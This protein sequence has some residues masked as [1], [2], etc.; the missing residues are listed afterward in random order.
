MRSLHVLHQTT[1]LH[2]W[3]HCNF[4]NCVARNLG[5][6]RYCDD[7]GLAKRN[8]ISVRTQNPNGL[9][10]RPAACSPCSSRRCREHRRLKC[11]PSCP[12]DT[13]NCVVC[14][15]LVLTKQPTPTTSLHQPDSWPI[16]LQF[17]KPDP[18]HDFG[19]RI[20]MLQGNPCTGCSVLACAV[21]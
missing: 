19:Q 17:S 4:E 18:K 6:T 8:I 10:R 15:S 14:I 11:Q 5:P 7:S 13:N 21:R 16:Q 9:H 1:T 20:R 2:I 3:I 12:N